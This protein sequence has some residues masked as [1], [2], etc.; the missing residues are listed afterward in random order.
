MADYLEKRSNR[1]GLKNVA[2]TAKISTSLFREFAEE[3]N[4][5][6]RFHGTL[7]YTKYNGKKWVD[8]PQR[9]RKE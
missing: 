4:K 8:L 3:V 9:F 5:G 7:W 6:K 1:K 2:S